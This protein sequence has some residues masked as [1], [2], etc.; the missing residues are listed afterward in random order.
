MINS[1]NKL[2]ADVEAEMKSD[3]AF[4]IEM[5][6]N[7]NACANWENYRNL[8]EIKSKIMLIR[9]L[10]DLINSG[11][12]HLRVLVGTKY[13]FD[14][15]YDDTIKKLNSM[16]MSISLALHPSLNSMKSFIDIL[17]DF[18]QRDYRE[19]DKRYEN[20]S[21]KCDKVLT[22]IEDIKE[23]YVFNPLFDEK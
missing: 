11:N 6:G 15:L 17:C 4:D 10:V 9:K 12:N 23:K 8:Q 16:D 22:V 21:K 13:D 20:F 5:W 7:I 14:I 3:K 2:K 1:H 19:D 18:K